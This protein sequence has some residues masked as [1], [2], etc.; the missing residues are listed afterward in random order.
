MYGGAKL[1]TEPEGTETWHELNR[2]QIHGYVVN[3]VAFLS[4]TSFVSGSDE[5]VVRV[6][7]APG[8]VLARLDL[9]SCA[10]GITEV[11]KFLRKM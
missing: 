1:K 4:R 11:I 9:L 8:S 6:F 10:K 3:T 7:E 5:S 2:T